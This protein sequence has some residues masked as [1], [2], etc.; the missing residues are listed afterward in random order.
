MDCDA[1]YRPPAP[2]PPAEPPPKL[3]PPPPPLEP[4]E[5]P[6]LP[7]L[8]EMRGITRVYVRVHPQFR[9]RSVTCWLPECDVV[10][11]ISVSVSVSSVRRLHDLQVE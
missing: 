10:A 8:W 2:P 4:P 3:L 11:G 7:E 1:Q 6:E 9:H 5:L